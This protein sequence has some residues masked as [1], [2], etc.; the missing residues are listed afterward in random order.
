MK[1]TEELLK[2]IKDMSILIEK[3]TFDA[4]QM[5][6]KLDNVILRNEFLE[7]KIALLENPKNSS[8]SSIPP[9]K[10]EN[11]PLK[12]QSL[13][14]SSGKSIGG[15]KGHKGSTLLFSKPTNVFKEVPAFCTVCGSSLDNSPEI[16]LERRQVIEIPPVLPIINEYQNVSKT[17]SCGHCTQSKFP[18]YVNAPVQYGKTVDA[19]IAYLS[20]R[21]YMPFNRIQEYFISNYCLNISQ[22]TIQNVLV[23]VAN[24]LTPAYNLIKLKIEQSAY[25]GGDETSVKVNGIKNW[26]WVLQNSLYSF[27]TCTSNRAFETLENLFPKGLPNAIVGHDC[28]SAWFKF[29]AKA[30]QACIAHIQREIK[31]FIETYTSCQWIKDLREIFHQSIEWSKSKR[32][33]VNDF[34]E[35]LFILLDNPPSETF[36]QL[37]PL[38][39]R[40]S[41]HRE[42]LL[43]FLDY[44]Y[45]PADNNGSERAIRNVKVKAKV[46]CQFKTLENANVFAIIRSVIDTLI[47][48][49]KNIL[50]ELFN[51]IQIIPE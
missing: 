33:T 15:Q 32:E 48:N 5:T 19:Q 14:G 26:M 30:H 41:K 23:R 35:K 37:K 10:D 6:L 38:V 27:I 13:R 31:F 21:Q 51:L 24:A 42:S 16:V 50:S 2:T 12:N 9:S 4:K 44:D 3:M 20:V 40:L 22:G 8:N 29:Q 17:C 7:A 36:S 39:K 1:S 49:N 18:L 28:Y 47:K 45:V 34:K 43:V 46:S 11:R 25:V